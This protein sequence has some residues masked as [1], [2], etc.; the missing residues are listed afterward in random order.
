LNRYELRWRDGFRLFRVVLLGGAV[1]GA[2]S[3]LLLISAPVAIERSVREAFVFLPWALVLGA[4]AGLVP[5]LFG[6]V[7][8]GLATAAL[9]GLD[10]RFLEP[11]LVGS[12]GAAGVLLAVCLLQAPLTYWS[13]PFVL[14]SAGV[15]L[16]A[17]TIVSI[18]ERAA[19]G[20]RRSLEASASHS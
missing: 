20:R 7:F 15:G 2:A 13:W 12:A 18:R 10:R 17:T 4:L 3:A 8:A 19:A 5:G 9:R 1:A 16:A 6:G 11:I 14:G